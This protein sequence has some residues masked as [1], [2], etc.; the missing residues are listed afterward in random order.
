RPGSPMA[1]AS[2]AIFGLLGCL[3]AW[4]L[5]NRSYL[6]RQLVSD[7]MRRLVWVI[8]INAFIS[9]MLRSIISWEAHLGGC[10]IGFVSGALLNQH[11][12]DRSVARW[13]FMLLVPLIPVV[14]IG[15]VVRAKE[16]SPTW[17][18]LAQI[19]AAEPERAKD[20]KESD[21]IQQF[22][23]DLLPVINEA[24]NAEV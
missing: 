23:R 8:A 13:V 18:K 9:F 15:A 11:R 5:L 24:H 2:G 7:W 4:L 21:E 22:N 12:F 16:S 6:P 3:P 10:V 1:G 20:R 14:C 17:R 19:V